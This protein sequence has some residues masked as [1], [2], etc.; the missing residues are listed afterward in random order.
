[1]PCGKAFDSGTNNSFD[2][3]AVMLIKTFVFD[4]D[5]S[6]GQ[7]FRY[8]VHG[9]R[10]TVGILSNQ[11]GRLVAVDII[12]EGGKTG[13]LYV[14]VADFRRGFNNTPKQA[15]A[16]ARDKDTRSHDGDKSNIK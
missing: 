7:I 8:H 16:G 4:R 3:D 10:D 11:F 9:D 14:D 13:R 6:V 1:M 2:V 15:E 12:Y 5:E